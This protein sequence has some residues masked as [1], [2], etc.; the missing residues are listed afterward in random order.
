[1]QILSHD[2]IHPYSCYAADW[3]QQTSQE[4]ESDF[5]LVEWAL[6]VI[7]KQVCDVFDVSSW[8][9]ISK[10]MFISCY[11]TFFP[12]GLEMGFKIVLQV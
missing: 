10:I 7:C 4:Y 12:S 1:M 3:E 5:N 8:K 6:K 11:F 2:N 9:G